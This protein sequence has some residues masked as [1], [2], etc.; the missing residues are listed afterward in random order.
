MQM[1]AIARALSRLCAGFWVIGAVALIGA[2]PAGQPLPAQFSP[3]Q[4][5]ALKELAKVRPCAAA[6]LLFL[7]RGTDEQSGVLYLEGVPTAA[8]LDLAL[9]RKDGSAFAT[10]SPPLRSPYS[11]SGYFVEVRWS[12]TRVDAS[13]WLVTTRAEIVDGIGAP[14][15]MPHVIEPAAQISVG[16]NG[17]QLVGGARPTRKQDARVL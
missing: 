12:I 15:L 13:S 3:T 17:L 8:T 7:G 11:T 2:A 16:A 10:V 9:D 4:R 1:A 5:E 14:L 6:A